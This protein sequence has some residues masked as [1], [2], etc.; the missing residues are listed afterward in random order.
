MQR[1]HRYTHVCETL[2]FRQGLPKQGQLTLV[3]KDEN[4]AFITAN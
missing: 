1:T 2:L 4:M 3:R